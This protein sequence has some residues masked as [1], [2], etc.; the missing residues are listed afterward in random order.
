MGPDFD[1]QAFFRIDTSDS[2]IDLPALLRRL[3]ELEELDG[4][5]AALRAAWA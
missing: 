5:A 1:P 4:A 2:S 3:E